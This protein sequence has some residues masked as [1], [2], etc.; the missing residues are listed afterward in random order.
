VLLDVVAEPEGVALGGAAP[1]AQPL[2]AGRGSHA[3]RALS[4]L[5]HLPA[6][7]RCSALMQS[8]GTPRYAAPPC[9]PSAAAVGTPPTPGAAAVARL[10][11][12]TTLTSPFVAQR[13]RT[14]TPREYTAGDT[15][16]YSAPA[17]TSHRHLAR[18]GLRPEA[19]QR[20]QH[21]RLRGGG[22]WLSSSGLTPP[23]FPLLLVLHGDFAALFA[24]GT[25]TAARPPEDAGYKSGKSGAGGVW[26]APLT[27]AS[28]GWPRT[29]HQ[30][31]PWSLMPSVVVHP[32]R[33]WRYTLYMVLHHVQVQLRSTGIWKP[34]C[35]TSFPPPPRF[36]K[37]YSLCTC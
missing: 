13:C 2:H 18:P 5:E 16:G 8:L 20:Q 31:D 28:L 10:S 35:T 11:L 14:S 4:P 32:P 19:R 22:S 21:L 17:R 15:A 12:S 34:R 1:P 7:A 27:T 36:G 30:L 29:A 25:A 6:R 33:R 24:G 37:P 23:A 3:G 26:H 9:L